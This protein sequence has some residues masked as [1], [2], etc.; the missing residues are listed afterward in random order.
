[1]KRLNVGYEVTEMQD[2]KRLNVGYEKTKCR[3]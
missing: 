3:I 1:M 2:M